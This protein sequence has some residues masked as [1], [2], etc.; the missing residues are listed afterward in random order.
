MGL[1]KEEIIK[2]II[3]DEKSGTPVPLFVLKGTLIGTDQ[4]L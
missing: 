4:Y 3:K 1:R 2:V